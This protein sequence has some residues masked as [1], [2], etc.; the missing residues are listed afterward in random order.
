MPA[1]N[2][3]WVKSLPM[4]LVKISLVAGNSEKCPNNTTPNLPQSVPLNVVY[5]LKMLT[6]CMQSTDIIVL[7]ARTPKK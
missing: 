1:L 5:V 2:S 3:K 6:F 4:V 7:A